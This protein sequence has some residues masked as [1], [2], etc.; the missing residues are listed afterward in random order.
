M[1]EKRKARLMDRMEMLV[2][3][4]QLVTYAALCEANGAYQATSEVEKNRLGAIAAAKANYLFAREPDD[5]YLADFNLSQLNEETETWLS[6]NPTFQ[7]L[8][9]QSLR[10]QNMVMYGRTGAVHDLIGAKLLGK[11]G[12]LFPVAPDPES[13]PTLIKRAL[14]E[15]NEHDKQELL[16][17]FARRG[18]KL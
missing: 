4:A 17:A 3:I 11:Y 18:I 15:L 13:Y 1:F 5:K 10:V 2:A 6:Q 9:V 8:V 7:E 12:E 14:D 16:D